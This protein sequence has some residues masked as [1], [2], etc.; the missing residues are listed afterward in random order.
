MNKC[1]LCSKSIPDGKDLFCSAYCRRQV[2][3]LVERKIQKMSDRDLMSVFHGFR[4]TLGHL[5]RRIR[6]VSV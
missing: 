3:K 2:E 6:G 1:I 5:K 4:L